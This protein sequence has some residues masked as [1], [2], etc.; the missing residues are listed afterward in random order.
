MHVHAIYVCVRAC[1]CVCERARVCVC[2]RACV[3]ACVCGWRGGGR[4]H[5]LNS[6]T[7]TSVTLWKALLPTA[8]F[9]HPME[10]FCP[11]TSAYQY[12]V[13]RTTVFS[14]RTLSY[15]D[16]NNNNICNKSSNAINKK[17]T[18]KRTCSPL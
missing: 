14:W 11:C 12:R 1:V 8:M 2:V 6:H 10:C 4:T 7:S 3:R 15:K 13:N 17:Q 9:Y 18:G 16:N 5:F